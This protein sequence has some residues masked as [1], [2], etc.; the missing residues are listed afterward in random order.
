MWWVHLARIEGD[1]L[2]LLSAVRG[3]RHRTDDCLRKQRLV[4][5]DA[6]YAL[7]KSSKT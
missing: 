5:M 3:P 2:S 7:Y 6:S 4:L 1:G